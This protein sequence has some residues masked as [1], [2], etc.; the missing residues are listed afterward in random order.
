MTSTH[1][2]SQS[3]QNRAIEQ[4]MTR[5]TVVIDRSAHLSEIARLFS[6]NHFTHLPVIENDRLIGIVSLND[7]LRAN[8]GENFGNDDEGD[9]SVYDAI[10]TIDDIMTPNPTT[11]GPQ[12][13]VK[14]AAQVMAQERF[15]SL[16]VVDPTTEEYLGLVTTTD[17]MS[18]IAEA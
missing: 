6:E 4:F 10:K 3:F 8:Y 12:C 5:E 7:L 9:L 14:E 1:T 15:H 16:P 2:E 11:I 18:S 13:T 17:I